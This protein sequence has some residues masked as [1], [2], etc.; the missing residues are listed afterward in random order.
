MIAIKIGM[1]EKNP[2]NATEP[3]TAVPRVTKN[4]MMSLLVA[5]SV[6]RLAPI[7]PPVTVLPA[8]SKP[9]KATTAPM[10]AGGRATSIHPIPNL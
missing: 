9:I 4:I 1:A 6:I 7:D 5:V 3:I 10:A 2:L 8:S